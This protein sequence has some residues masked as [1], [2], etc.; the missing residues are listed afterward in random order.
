M[1]LFEKGWSGTT[2]NDQT[3]LWSR[4]E[5]YMAPN[6]RE[7]VAHAKYSVF[8]FFTNYED[9]IWLF[10]I[11]LLRIS[12]RNPRNYAV[13]TG[14]RSVISNAAARSTL[15]RNAVIRSVKLMHKRATRP[16]SNYAISCNRLLQEDYFKKTTS[17]RLSDQTQFQEMR[18]HEVFANK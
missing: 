12:I 10:V 4:W 1:C 14:V 8:F 17:R 11:T 13:T 2:S 6:G 15:M 9:V 5:N 18:V 7:L 16:T 3:Q